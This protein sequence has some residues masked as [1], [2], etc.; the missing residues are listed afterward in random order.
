LNSRTNGLIF[1]EK[2]A[3][4]QGGITHHSHGYLA[5]LAPKHD[6]PRTEKKNRIKLAK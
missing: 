1:K 5:W 4:R 2:A 3:H 6:H